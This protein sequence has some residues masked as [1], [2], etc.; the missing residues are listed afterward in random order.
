MHDRDFTEAVWSLDPIDLD[1]I[2]QY[3]QGKVS[4]DHNRGLELKIPIG[5]L[6]G[7]RK[8]DGFYYSSIEPH[9]ATCAYGF[10]QSGDYLTMTNIS[11]D[12][13]GF[14]CP[15]FQCQTILGQ[16][17]IVSKAPAEPNPLITSISA[18]IPGL[19]EWIAKSPCETRLM[20]DEATSKVNSVG[21]N[22]DAAKAEDVTL[23]ESDGVKI[24]ANYSG[25]YPG[26]PLPRY[27]FRFIDDYKL[28]ISF[29]KPIS[30]DE[31]F[32]KWLIRTW[33]FI[34][35]CIGF[36]SS[37][38]SI[39][40]INATTNK[41]CEYYVPLVEDDGNADPDA[42]RK[43]PFSYK[44]I[45]DKVQGMLATWLNLDDYIAEA[46]G[47]T[48][49]LLSKQVMP[50]D[51]LFLA[52]SH[53]LEG[54]SSTYASQK[55]KRSGH[56]KP[57]A[58]HEKQLLDDLEP[59]PSKLIPN[60]E[61]FLQLQTENRNGYTHLNRSKQTLV[62]DELY[63]HMKAVQLLDYAAAMHAIGVEPAEILHA[64]DESRYRANDQYFIRQMYSIPETESTE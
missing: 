56:F 25:T 6:F 34:S 22:Y 37:V 51:M 58:I 49:N 15:G 42:L 20:I 52:S 38:D 63:W 16:A 64:L 62:H 3:V 26:G 4:F 5:C 60:R 45:D 12:D 8:G 39:E 11:A 29:D 43:I 10:S 47:L 21:F 9:T 41:K 44:R 31:A 1:N 46:A 35:L 27:E 55:E 50:L 23:F 17:L 33:N 36:R 28:R 13:P 2:D 18:R 53:A 40:F 7:L 30:L 59:L 14:S 54:F 24:S 32:S 57:A 48:V 61:A 19:R